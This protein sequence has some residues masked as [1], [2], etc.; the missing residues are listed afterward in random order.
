MKGVGLPLSWS[1][2]ILIIA[3]VIYQVWKLLQGTRGVQVLTG[4]LIVLVV[5][6]L[7]SAVLHLRVVTELIRLFSPSFFV[8]LVVLFQPELRQ[9]LAEVG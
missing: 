2:E 4:L 6:T 7:F 1:L 3:I 5:L 9:V 8:A